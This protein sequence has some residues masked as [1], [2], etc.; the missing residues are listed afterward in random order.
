MKDLKIANGPHKRFVKLKKSDK[1]ILANEI[2]K[3]NEINRYPYYASDITAYINNQLRWDY[4]VQFVRSFIKMN[5]TL[6][7]RE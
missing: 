4:T 3:F 5:L 7:I 1:K 2:I 6:L